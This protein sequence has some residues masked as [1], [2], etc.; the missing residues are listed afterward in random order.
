MIAAGGNLYYKDPMTSKWA[1]VKRSGAGKSEAGK[2]GTPRATLSYQTIL[3]TAK[4]ITEVTD[5]TSTVNGVLVEHYRIVPDL[6]KLLA[7]ASAGHS[8]SNPA[9]MTAL[10]T[11]LQD[12]T[13]VA[14]VWTGTSDHLVHRLSYDADVTAD[15][16]Q[17]AGAMSS[18]AAA[19]V[20][21]FNLPA[22]SIGHVTA[23]I[24]VDLHDFNTR[25]TI[26]APAVAG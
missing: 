1:L 7:Q 13:L 24:V 16:H 22:G 19:K 10:Q 20:P 23:H 5:S 8:P 25:L 3:D 21:A 26:Q 2:A 6:L 18:Q 12:A 11:V 17:L 14:D 4:S 15:L 9:A